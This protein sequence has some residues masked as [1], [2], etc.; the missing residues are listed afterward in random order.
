MKLSLTL[1]GAVVAAAVASPALAIE[2]G[3]INGDWVGKGFVQADEKSRPVNV[4]CAV[5]GH[6]EGDVIGFEGECRAMLVVRREIGANL[7]RSGDSYTGT[8]KGANVGLAQL[9]G[10]A[11][12]GNTVDL[13]MTFPR[14]VNGDTLARMTIS[15]PGDGTFTVKTEDEMVSGETVTTS[16]ITFARK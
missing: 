11:T 6:H 10:Q 1:M 9:V 3:N 12:D 7:T 5:E 13:T 14:A 8:Y 16:E 2:A 4:N 15:L